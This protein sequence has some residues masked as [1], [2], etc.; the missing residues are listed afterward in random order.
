MVSLLFVIKLVLFGQWPEE[1]FP[2]STASQRLHPSVTWSRLEFVNSYAPHLT[3][4]ITIRKKKKK[5]NKYLEADFGAERAPP[6][7]QSQTVNRG[8][9]PRDSRSHRDAEIRQLSAKTSW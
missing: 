6:K 5:K 3:F 4:N 8:E 7:K 1:A 9:N 2:V